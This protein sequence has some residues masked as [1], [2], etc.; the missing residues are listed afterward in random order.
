MEL[1]LP[2]LYA[3]WFKSTHFT[4]TIPAPTTILASCSNPSPSP[5]EICRTCP[6]EFCWCPARGSDLAGHFVQQ[7]SIFAGYQLRKMS[8]RGSKCPTEHWGPAGQNVQQTWNNFARTAPP[9]TPYLTLT[10]I[11]FRICFES[12]H[13]TQ[14][15][16][17]FVHFCVRLSREVVFSVTSVMF[18][19][20]SK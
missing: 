17:P 8:D 9:Q 14:T 3:P 16:H 7:D 20:H 10:I 1:I 4:Q 6:A 11:R 15:V 13:F 5:C 18:R 2:L 12:T 19:K